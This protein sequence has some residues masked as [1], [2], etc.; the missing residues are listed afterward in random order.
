LKLLLASKEIRIALSFFSF[1]K[2]TKYKQFLYI[3]YAKLEEKKRF[4]N[5]ASMYDALFCM[6]TVKR[7]FI[8]CIPADLQKPA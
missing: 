2:N 4:L 3:D 8:V 7:P 6:P 1:A 5:F